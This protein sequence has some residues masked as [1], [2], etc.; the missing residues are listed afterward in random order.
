M[1]FASTSPPQDGGK[2]L[3]HGLF[4]FGPFSRVEGG[5]VGGGGET[6]SVRGAECQLDWEAAFAEGGMFFEVEA[7]L[8]FYLGFWGVV[9][10]GNFD[11]A[12]VMPVDGQRHQ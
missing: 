8:Q 5:P 12:L 3:C 11:A 4:V 2:F 6:F 10:V 9:D 1:S 7:V